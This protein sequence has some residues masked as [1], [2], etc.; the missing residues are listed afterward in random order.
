MKRITLL[1]VQLLAAVSLSLGQSD[2]WVNIEKGSALFLNPKT[3]M[4]E[5]IVG[6]QQ[7]PAKTYV[8][9]KDQAVLRVFKET[10]VLSAPAGGYFF[11]ADIFLRDRMQV[12][13]ELT[14]IEAQQLPP[15]SRPDTADEK[16]VVGLTYGVMAGRAS[17]RP[18]I[19]YLEERIKAVESF[20]AQKRYDAALLSL[21]RTMALFP[22]LYLHSRLASLLCRLYDSLE[23]YGFLY[24]ET[25]RLM[26]VQK[27]GDFGTMIIQWNELAKNK[28]T[29]R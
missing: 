3:M 6:K 17:S 26:V 23:L 16:K 14:A 19:P 10:D 1:V 28:L 5:P 24:E 15:S 4:W 22:A 12:V 29:K 7:L 8:L 13:E 2:I 18:S 21:K 11:L 25:N 9:T 20:Q 27:E